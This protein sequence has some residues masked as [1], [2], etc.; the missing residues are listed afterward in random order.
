MPPPVYSTQFIAENIFTDDLG[1]D[2]TVPDGKIAVIRSITFSINSTSPTGF[3]V[4]AGTGFSTL[5]NQIVPPGWTGT[6][7]WN[8][9]HVSPAGALLVMN[10]QGA[11]NP[12]DVGLNM[13]GYLLTAP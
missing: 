2:Y 7:I 5:F 9:R 3:P 11:G 6:L 4:G 10:A 1:A 12:C 13:S 8:G